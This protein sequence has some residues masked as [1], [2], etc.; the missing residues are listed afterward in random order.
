MYIGEISNIPTGDMNELNWR[1]LQLSY[2]VSSQYAEALSGFQ[3]R[4]HHAWLLLT[5]SALHLFLKHKNAFL[6]YLNTEVVQVVDT[7]P[8]GQQGL[9]YLAQSI[10][11]L[12]MEMDFLLKK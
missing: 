10:P 4:S 6:S 5:F 2:Q 11:L 8:G 3:F 1:N 7:F 9:T 12:L